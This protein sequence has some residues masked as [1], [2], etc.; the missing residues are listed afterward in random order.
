[1]FVTML[2]TFFISVTQTI[3]VAGHTGHC[4]T[5]STTLTTPVLF[6]EAQPLSKQC[7]YCNKTYVVSMNFFGSSKNA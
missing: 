4:K 5:L 1:V 6:V 7:L 2:E 3:M